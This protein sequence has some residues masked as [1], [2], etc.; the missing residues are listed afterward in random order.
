METDNERFERYLKQNE[1][2]WFASSRAMVVWAEQKVKEGILKP[3]SSLIPNNQRTK[4]WYVRV[5]MTKTEDL[6]P[7]F[8]AKGLYELFGIRCLV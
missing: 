4:Y 1:G 8:Q 6:L 3:L 2:V 7:Y 5:E